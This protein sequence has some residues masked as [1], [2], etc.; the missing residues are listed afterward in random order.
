MADCS[1]N[2]A[3]SRLTFLRSEHPQAISG[4][5]PA[6]GPLEE[7]EEDGRTEKWGV[8]LWEESAGILSTHVSVGL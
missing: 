6:A 5:E 2:E 3:D 7:V 1:V 4:R 8:A